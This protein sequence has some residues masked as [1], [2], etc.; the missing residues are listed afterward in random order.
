VE[1]MRRGSRGRGSRPADDRESLAGPAAHRREPT[2]ADAF[3]DLQHSAG[4]R[5]IA[6]ALGGAVVQRKPGPSR[7][8]DGGTLKLG[9]GE[10]IPLQSATWSLNTAIA[11]SQMGSQRRPTIHAAANTAGDLTIRRR[12]DKKSQLAIDA[13]GTDFQEGSLRLTRP[14]KDGA[15]PAT[16]MKLYEVVL[17]TY[18]SGSEEKPSETL[19]L[20]VGWMKV[21]GMGKEEE[22]GKTKGKRPSGGWELRV[23]G[24]EMAPVPLMSVRYEQPQERIAPD[25]GLSAH[26]GGPQPFNATVTMGAGMGLTRLAKAQTEGRALDLTFALGG[27]ERLQLERALVK[28]ISSTSDGPAVVE[29]SFA[30]EQVRHPAPSGGGKTSGG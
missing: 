2:V 14:S 23:A 29:V 5:S 24:D 13:M 3:M 22:P 25:V 15:I 8:N 30:A 21:S 10:E 26:P 12:P 28:S 9:G 7:K 11:V 6:S 19:V 16:D 17:S 20:G 1:R 27:A 4:N 18:Q